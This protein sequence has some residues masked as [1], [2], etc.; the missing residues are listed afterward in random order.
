MRAAA[1]RTHAS[2]QVVVSAM[3][4]G[5]AQMGNLYRTMSRADAIGVFDAARA[6]G[7]RYFDTAPFYGFTRSER[8]LGAL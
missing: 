6:A 5:C 1:P 8:R 4:L 2:S 3:G 7:I